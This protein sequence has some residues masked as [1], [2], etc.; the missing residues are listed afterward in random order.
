MKNSS[1][2]SST[3]MSS[4]S[5][6]VITVFEHQWLRVGDEPGGVLFSQAHWEAL[7]RL[8]PALPLPYYALTHR[9]IR[10]SHYVGALKTPSLTLEVL[11]KAD[12]HPGA[13]PP[14]WR[15]LLVAM[16]AECRYL[17]RYRQQVPMP[18]SQADVL[19]DVFLLDFLA[20]VEGL[21]RQG[22]VKQYQPTEENARAM[23]GHLLFAQHLRRNAVHQERFFV[24][25]QVHSTQHPMHQLLKQALHVVAQWST[26]PLVQR[27]SHRLLHYFASVSEAPNAR[28][29][30]TSFTYDRQTAA[31][32]P[33]ITFAQQVLAARFSHVYHGHTH[34]GFAL[35]LDM[36]LVFEE[37]IYQRLRKL[38]SVQGFAVHRQTTRS[39][40]GETKVR[41]DLV[42]E[43]PG[44]Q[45]N[46]VIDTKWKVLTKPRPAA[47]DL[48]QLYVYNQLF[49]ARKGILLYPNV[50]DLPLRRQR[51]D[52]PGHSYAEVNF[53]KIAS[54]QGT[55]LN[56]RL[57][58]SLV[59]LLQLPALESG[60]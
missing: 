35:L 16:L 30:S 24:R 14:H 13:S 18:T 32:R 55:G 25:H 3:C 6:P 11:P 59:A 40:W 22:L 56:P 21:C 34:Q 12:A 23:K 27:Q 43:L 57:D 49:Q 7:V 39:L 31:Y 52:G 1:R 51:F 19:L 2:Q 20:E 41:P 46:L 42:V 44:G 36:N 37:F 54:D 38:A 48:H 33:A 10:L 50:Y 26:H 47:Q 29:L 4:R 17:K 15:Q 60:H 28:L 9:G 53:I 8:H 45:G 5:L 58:E